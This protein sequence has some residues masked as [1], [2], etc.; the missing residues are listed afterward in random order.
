MNYIVTSPGYTVLTNPRRKRRN[1]TDHRD[2]TLGSEYPGFSH[3][4]KPCDTRESSTHQYTSASDY[5]YV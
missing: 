3:N 2:L 4:P 5:V 1:T